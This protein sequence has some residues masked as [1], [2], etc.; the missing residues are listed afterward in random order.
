MMGS[1][2]LSMKGKGLVKGEY[3][4]GLELGREGMLPTGLLSLLNISIMH[5]S[6]CHHRPQ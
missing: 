5:E 6:H 3:Y 2:F 4:K 1:L